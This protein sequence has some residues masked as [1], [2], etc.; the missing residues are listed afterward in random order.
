MRSPQ[1]Y[2]CTARHEWLVTDVNASTQ[3]KQGIILLWAP[4][5]RVRTE[6]GS[7]GQ[8]IR[9][10][11]CGALES[12]AQAPS[13]AI[14]NATE[15]T[16]RRRR[17]QLVCRR[18]RGFAS[19]AWNEVSAARKQEHEQ[20]GR[21]REAQLFEGKWACCEQDAAGRWTATFLP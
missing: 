20:W 4:Q 8:R 5:R 2:T 17:R 14:A 10:K 15:P 9:H 1:N 19:A 18:K 13:L 3:R 16:S 12:S 21:D 6:P 11:K 7:E